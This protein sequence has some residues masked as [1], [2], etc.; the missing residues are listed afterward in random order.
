MSRVDRTKR[1]I[2]DLDTEIREGRGDADR[3]ENLR[4]ATDRLNELA[5]AIRPE[6]TSAGWHRRREIIR[7]LV[8]RIDIE[9]EVIRIIFRVTQNTRG[10]DSNSIAVT[11]ARP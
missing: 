3:R 10:S 8:Q 6:L 1:R 2:A 5:A 7:T 11:L 9:T 4:F